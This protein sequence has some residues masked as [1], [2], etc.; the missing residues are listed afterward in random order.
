MSE[1]PS[2]TVVIEATTVPVVDPPAVTV[3]VAPPVDYYFDSYSHYGIHMEMLKDSHRTG[4]YRDSILMNAHVFKDKVVLDVGCGTGI[5]SMFAAKAGARKVIGVD[6]S[7]IANQASEVVKENGFE[8]VITIIKGKIEELQIEDKVDIIISEWM[9][10]FLLYESMLNTVLYARDK[11]GKKGVLLFPDR[12][13]MYIQGITDE[14]YVKSKFNVWDNV[15][16]FDFSYYKRLSYIEPL[17]DTVDTNQVVTNTASLVSLDLRSCTLEDLAFSSTFN[18]TANFDSVIHALSVH[19][20][21]PFTAGH[22]HVVLDTSHRRPPTHWRQTVLYLYNPLRIR[23]GEQVH[24]TMKCKPNSGN[25]RD[26]DI[27]LHV[28]FD[29]TLQ[30]SHFDQDFRLR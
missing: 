28:D 29:G 7:S 23:G 3:I 11:F 14:H 1:D 21:T 26:L 4:T 10:Y 15:E 22:E 16:G 17:I 13:N 27:D 25:P 24:C 6:C 12:A 8:G 18:L 2:T 20:D 30:V 9:G 19:F 5:L